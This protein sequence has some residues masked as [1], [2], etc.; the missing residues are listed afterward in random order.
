MRVDWFL[1]A[2]TI[3][4]MPTIWQS[5]QFDLQK[6]P[7]TD[8]NPDK[9]SWRFRLCGELIMSQIVIPKDILEATLHGLKDQVEFVDESGEVLGQFTPAGID[10]MLEAPIPPIEELERR[11]NEPGGRTIAEIMR[12]LEKLAS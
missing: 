7:V 6:L 3:K 5:R 11:N 4:Q 8:D 1:S 2:G 12:D 10:W 9:P